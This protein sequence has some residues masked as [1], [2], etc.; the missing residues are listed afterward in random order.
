MPWPFSKAKAPARNTFSIGEYRLD[1]TIEGLVGLVE[2]SP[3]EYAIMGRNFDGE[4][5]YN[6]P[7]V[8][9]LG[10]SWKLMLG[11]V[12]GRIYKTAPYLEL[13]NKQEANPI[14]ME[15][16]LYCTEQLGKPSKQET[17]LFIWDTSDGNVIL[18]TAE[19]ADGFGINLFLTSRAIRNFTRT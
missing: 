7:P 1:A 12:H 3:D 4:R 14:A 16:L 11:T 9:F 10:R 17:G 8:N 15:T 19:I 18:Q 5:N 13:R 2:F 6:A